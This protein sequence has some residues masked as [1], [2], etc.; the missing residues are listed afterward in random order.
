M[1]SGALPGDGMT[2]DTDLDFK[3]TLPLQLALDTYRHPSQS[4]LPLV[5][6]EYQ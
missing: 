3:G 5:E 1:V 6:I 2:K 4:Q